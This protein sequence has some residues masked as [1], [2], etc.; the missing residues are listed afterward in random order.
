MEGLIRIRFYVN[1]AVELFKIKKKGGNADVICMLSEMQHMHEGE[2][3]AGRKR[4]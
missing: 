1:I 3:M 2:E 4:D